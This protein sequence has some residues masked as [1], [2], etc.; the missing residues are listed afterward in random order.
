M[1]APTSMRRTIVVRRRCTGLSLDPVK[2]RLLLLKGA[3]VNAKTVDGRTPLHLAATPPS[4]TPIV[5]ML[6]EAGAGP[7]RALHRRRN[8]AAGECGHEPRN[9]TIAAGEGRRP[10]CAEWPRCDTTDE[11]GPARRRANGVVAARR[12]R[13]HHPH[14]AWRDCAG[15]CRESRRP[16]VGEASTRVLTCGTST[17]AVTPMHAAYADDGT[18]ELIQL[19]LAKGADVHVVGR[20]T[21]RARLPSPLRL[22]TRRDRNSPDTSRRAAVRISTCASSLRHLHRS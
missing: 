19:L 12:R 14:Q 15:Q 2:V 22:A 20:G 7:A 13:C 6:I 21:P 1:P 11:R 8:A 3:N 17:T 10:Q 4:G 16:V 18:P 5:E 9:N